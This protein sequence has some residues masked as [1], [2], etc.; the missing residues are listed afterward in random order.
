MNSLPDDC[1]AVKNGWGDCIAENGEHEWVAL[2]NRYGLKDVAE[3]GVLSGGLVGKVMSSCTIERYYG[4]DPWKVFVKWSD[5]VPLDEEIEKERSQ[6][7]NWKHRWDQNYYDEMYEKVKSAIDSKHPEVILIREES[8]NAAKQIKDNS[9]DGVYLD[10]VHDF[11]NTLNDIYAWLPKV[12][13]NG[14]IAGHDYMTRFMGLIRIVDYVFGDDLV[15]PKDSRKDY[16]SNQWYVELS[17]AKKQKFS[18]RIRNKFKNPEE[19]LDYRNKYIH[20]DPNFLDNLYSDRE[21]INPFYCRT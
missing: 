21:F 8:V 10:A 2:I 19:L 14:I 9:L 18:D 4:I 13:E 17:A 12:K 7:P 1:V 11:P 20:L 5:D 3:I 6:L 16:F 15:V